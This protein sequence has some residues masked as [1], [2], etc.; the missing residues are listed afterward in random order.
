[1]INII[2]IWFDAWNNASNNTSNNSSISWLSLLTLFSSISKNLHNGYQ[3]R[4]ESKRSH[5][6]DGSPFESKH[7]FTWSFFGSTRSEVVWRSSNWGN[8]SNLV[9]KESTD[10]YP[11]YNYKG[12]DTWECSGQFKRHSIL[13]VFWYASY[14]I[15]KSVC[16]IHESYGCTRD[17]NQ[18]DVKQEEEERDKDQSLSGSIVISS[19]VNNC[20]SNLKLFSSAVKWAIEDEEANTENDSRYQ[21]SSTTPLILTLSLW[22][23]V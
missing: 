22:V 20:N 17:T 9:T 8:V 5:V 2:N 16:R 14:I 19:S 1:M 10:P 7:N 4:T 23:P 18:N 3:E 13:I 15:Y 11:N 12:K 6:S 21:K